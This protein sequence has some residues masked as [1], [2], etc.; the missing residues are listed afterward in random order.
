MLIVL[1]EEE[2][3]DPLLPELHAARMP[4]APVASAPAPRPRSTDRRAMLRS[5]DGS[6]ADSSGLIFFSFILSASGPVTAHRPPPRCRTS[7]WR[8]AAQAAR[9][10]CITDEEL[11]WAPSH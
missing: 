8:A 6:T 2:A 3:D 10:Q 5:C 4:P 1:V 7:R 11:V 9:S